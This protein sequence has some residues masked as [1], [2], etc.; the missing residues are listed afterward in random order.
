MPNDDTDVVRPIPN[1]GCMLIISSI[2]GVAWVLSSPLN[3][4]VHHLTW[5]IE[6]GNAA[7]IPCLELFPTWFLWNTS[8]GNI[9]KRICNNGNSNNVIKWL[10]WIAGRWKERKNNP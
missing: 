9:H 7:W 5:W 1:G 3:W 6:V 4:L 2:S 10:K 8:N